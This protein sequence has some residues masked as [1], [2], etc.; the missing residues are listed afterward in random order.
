MMQ[1]GN[2]TSQVANA[3]EIH[4]DN[5]AK[6]STATIIFPE[7]ANIALWSRQNLNGKKKENQGIS[8]P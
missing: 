3:E 4:E 2:K 5:N 1:D 6:D 7:D 8:A